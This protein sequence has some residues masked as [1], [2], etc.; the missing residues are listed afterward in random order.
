MMA[1]RRPCPRLCPSQAELDAFRHAGVAPLSL[2][3]PVAMQVAVGGIAPDGL[4][5]PNAEGERWFTFEEPDTDDIVFWHRSTGRLCS[6]SGRAFALG[7]EIINEA[8]TY[9]FDCALNIFDNPTDWLIA[10]RDGIVVLPRQWH[11]AFERLRDCPRIAIAQSL[12]QRY[13]QRMKPACLPELLV[14]RQPLRS[15]A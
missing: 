12:V 1:S 13:R 10:R 14:L 9:S 15:V 8:A 7:Q 2:A 3:K 5:E 11:L 6:W 4:F